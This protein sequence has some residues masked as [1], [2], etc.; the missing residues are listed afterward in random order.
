MCGLVELTGPAAGMTDNDQHPP[1]ITLDRRYLPQ[2]DD[3]P[4]DL[5]GGWS[6]VG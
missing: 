2:E 5:S 4:G 6:P 3:L 1:G